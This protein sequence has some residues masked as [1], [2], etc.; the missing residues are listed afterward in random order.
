MK[1]GMIALLLLF[2]N[3]VLSLL[4]LSIAATFFLADVLKARC[5]L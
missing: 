3:E 1:Y 2:D 5:N 4:V